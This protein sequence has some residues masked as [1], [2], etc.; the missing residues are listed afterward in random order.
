MKL[1]GL[2]VLFIAAPLASAIA[3]A[4]VEIAVSGSGAIVRE[5]QSAQY[6]KA[7]VY[8]RRQTEKATSTSSLKP[9]KDVSASASDNSNVAVDN[10]RA[11]WQSMI[12]VGVA[13]IF[14]KTWFVAFTLALRSNRTV[15]FWGGFLGLLLHVV[16]AAGMGFSLSRVFPLSLLNFVSAAVFGV[17][18]VFYTMEWRACEKDS[19][20]MA[21]GKEEADEC[22]NLKGNEYQSWRRVF[23]HTVWL[24]FL[25]EWGDRTQIAMIGLHSS[26]PLLP[27]C[28]G[29]A[30]AF[31]LLTMS[32]V[33]TASLVGEKKLSES[34]VKAVS[35]ASF[36]VFTIVALHDGFAERNDEM[37]ASLVHVQAAAA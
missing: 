16:I 5:D 15:V 8:A 35:A 12:T 26:K 4:K 9:Q 28:I 21:A 29:S 6:K 19:D 14:D 33:V 10:I 20:I 25:A 17:F 23:A 31:L 11:M 27:V 18:A 37:A 7:A 2:C 22:V 30:M 36:A 34:L 32:A 1:V 24:M 3:E 13:E